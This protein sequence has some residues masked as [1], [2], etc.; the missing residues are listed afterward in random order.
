MSIVVADSGAT[1]IDWVWTDGHQ[2]FY[3]ETKGINPASQPNFA[4]QPLGIDEGFKSVEAVYFYGAG[5]TNSTM[6]DS[7]SNYLRRNGFVGSIFMYSDVLGAARAIFQKD[8]GVICILGTGS[9]CAGYDGERIKT[10]KPSLGYIIG[11]EGSGSDLGKEVL[12]QYFYNEM[13]EVI[14]ENFRSIYN[15]TKDQLIHSLYKD[16]G[17]AAFL[18]SFANF[19]TEWK[20]HEWTENILT[21][22]FDS[23]INRKL[24]EQIEHH[25]DKVGFVGSIAFIHKKILVK[26]L[27]K[28]GINNVEF[29]QRPLDNLLRYHLTYN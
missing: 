20:D 3:A 25:N 6:V 1:K 12:R 5:I 7:M 17:G 28:A 21:V 2:K 24:K 4:E 22:L 27:E 15:L 18:A 10:L 9:V 16:Q 8:I 14:Q 11:D 13:P 26:S 23:F 19:L 29:L